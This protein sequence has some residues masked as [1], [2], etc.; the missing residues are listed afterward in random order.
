M[1][2][3]Q[4]PA[5]MKPPIAPGADSQAPTNVNRPPPSSDNIDVNKIEKKIEKIVSSF[6]DMAEELEKNTKVLKEQRDQAKKAIEAQIKTTNLAAQGKATLEELNASAEEAKKAKAIVAELEKEEA[7]LTATR[8]DNTK[9]TINAL[10]LLAKN[11]SVINDTAEG[12][13]GFG[14]ELE[15]AKEKIEELKKAASELSGG[16]KKGEA[17]DI[18]DAVKKLK[19]ATEFLGGGKGELKTREYISE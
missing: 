17:V 7:G 4:K 14:G 19:D 15:G 9:K 12:I 5:E 2:D 10:R 6:E 11:I 13:A 3:P 16:L 1:A 18:E 8:T